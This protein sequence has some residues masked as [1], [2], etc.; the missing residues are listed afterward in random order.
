MAVGLHQ[1]A[2]G[3]LQVGGREPLREQIKVRACDED[4]K[5]WASSYAN[6][7]KCVW[8]AGEEAPA[9]S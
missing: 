5:D 4:P 8:G 2:V 7:P 1:E 6:V 3:S 9:F